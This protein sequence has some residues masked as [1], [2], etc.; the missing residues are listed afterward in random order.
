M[1]FRN[2]VS[3]GLLMILGLTACQSNPTGNQTLTTSSTEGIEETE[4]A[5]VFP[6]DYAQVCN[7]IAFTPAAT[8]TS[9]T[10]EVHPLYVFDREKDT[11]A[12]SK[13]YRSLPDG[14]E[15]SWEESQATQ[16]V[17]C[18]TVTQETLANSC[19][20]PP[21]EGETEAY[22]LETY[23]TNYAVEIYA[24]NS[25]EQL[26][27]TTFEIQGAE[28]PMFHMFTEGEYTDTSS[29]D[30]SQALLEFVKPYV[31]PDV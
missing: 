24:A 9:T 8:Y 1:N 20:F 4:P 21:D 3:T 29:A 27:N 6:D 19:E 10:G 30:Y 26:D 11:D 23:N 15:K 7:G 12:F 17:A 5:Q 2:Q 28:C 13:S 14:W 16:L 25:G 18:L 31:Q 22:V